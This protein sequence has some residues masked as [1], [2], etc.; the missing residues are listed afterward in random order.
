[1]QTKRPISLEREHKSKAENVC[2]GRSPGKSADFWKSE[3]VKRDRGQQAS[4]I[5]S[6]CFETVIGVDC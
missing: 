2:L 5:N 3:T 4:F 6:T 1:M